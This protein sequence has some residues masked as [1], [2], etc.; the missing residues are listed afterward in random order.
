M[1]SPPILRSKAL[2]P[3]E[4]DGALREWGG[5]S[6][7]VDEGE[8]P[9]PQAIAAARDLFG[10]PRAT[11]ADLA[12]ERSAHFR[13]WSEMHNERDWREQLHLGRERPDSGRSPDFLGLE[14]PN[15]WP[16]DLEFRRAMSGYIDATAAL[17]ETI[18]ARLAEALHL[19]DAPFAGIGGDGYLV[20]KLIGYHPQASSAG[21]RPGVAPHVDFSWL[22]LTLQ[23]SPG[24][25]VRAPGGRW[26]LIEPRP[27]VLWVHAGELL[28]FATG[29][30]YQAAPHRVI[31]HSLDRMRVSI[32]LF[33]NPPL[34][35]EVPVFARPPTPLEIDP[36][37]SREHVHRVLTPSVPAVPFHF[38]E[39]EWRRKGLGQWC[40]TCVPESPTSIS[41][42]DES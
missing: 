37:A 36:A 23:D 40:A 6:I 35:A 9:W 13:G 5:F 1:S 32:P 7:E 17:A 27:G 28:Q 39:A 2:A 34:D 33:V 16:T 31:N 41:P 26:T 3:A 18:L 25:E 42:L 21:S 24:L 30:R 19:D 15:L 11:K 20:M 8:L 10:H 14:G 4:V 12:I 29:G 38:G 22:T